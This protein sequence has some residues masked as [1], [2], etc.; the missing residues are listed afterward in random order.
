A[1]SSDGTRI[2]VSNESESVLDVVDAATGSILRKIGLT[3]NP[4]NIAITKDGRRVVVGIR[5][6]P[7][8]LDVIDTSS[9]T[10]VKTIPV[11]GSVHNVYVT[12][13]G[14]YA[15]SG[16]IENKAATV[17]DLQTERVAW[18]VKFDCAVRP[19]AFSST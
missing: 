1:F 14:K 18:E 13:D 10:R 6:Q 4:N 11:D 7:G 5:E 17:V 19:M 9:L 16:S 8:F 12:P 15:V 3:A 2:Y